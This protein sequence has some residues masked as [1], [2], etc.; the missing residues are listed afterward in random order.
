MRSLIAFLVIAF[1]LGW[2]S[3][4][5][6]NEFLPAALEYPLTRSAKE[7]S[8]PSDF[9]KESSINVYPDYVKIN[10]E[11]SYLAGYTD[12]NSMDP[13]LDENSNGIE[14]PYTNQELGEGN[15]ISYS[16]GNKLLVHRIVGTGSDPDGKYFLVRGDNSNMT[17]MVRG[18]QVNGILTGIIY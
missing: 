11:N 18:P 14:I 2:A 15:I 9:V 17:H 7:V 10:L 6:T 8:S 1:C 4:I 16:L 12:T 5:L 3:N 13:T